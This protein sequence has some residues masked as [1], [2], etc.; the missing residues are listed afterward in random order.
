[1]WIRSRLR[2]QDSEPIQSIYKRRDHWTQIIEYEDCSSLAHEQHKMVLS[3]RSDDDLGEKEGPAGP[4]GSQQQMPLGDGVIA[5]IALVREY[6]PL[7][8]TSACGRILRR[9]AEVHR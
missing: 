8:V 7:R 5:A 2:T 6:L 1:M 4:A 9:Y 3:S